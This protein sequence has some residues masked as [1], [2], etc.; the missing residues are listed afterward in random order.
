MAVLALIAGDTKP[1]RL[2]YRDKATGAAINVTGYGFVITI[3]YSPKTTKA[4]VL[5]PEVTGAFEFQWGSTDLVAGQPEAEIIVTDADGKTQTHK[6]GALAIG[7]R[8]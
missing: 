1:T 6:L 2:I 7:A 3:G 4:A 5:V 8:L